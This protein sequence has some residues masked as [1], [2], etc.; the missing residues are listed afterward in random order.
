MKDRT[1]DRTECPKSG[2]SSESADEPSSARKENAV[3]LESCINDKKC[4]NES[5]NM[6][7][8]QSADK[9]AGT[10]NSVSV[11]INIKKKALCTRNQSYWVMLESYVLQLLCVQKEL[12]EASELDTVKKI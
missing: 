5:G 6:V 11:R 10:E 7:Q 1:P 9:D 8:Y 3:K 2:V 12:M 4:K